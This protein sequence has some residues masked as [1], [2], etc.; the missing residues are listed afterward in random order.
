MSEYYSEKLSAER[1]KQCYEIAPPRTQQYLRAEIQ[2]ILQ[3]ITS[4]SRVLELGCGYGRVLAAMKEKCSNLVGIDISEESLAFAHNR[5]VSSNLALVL[6]NANNLAFTDCTFDAVVCI[7]NGISAFK[8]S[9]CTVIQEAVRVTAPGGVCLFSSY[10][11]HFWDSRLEWFKVQSDA[12]L[13]GPID[14]K[15]TK[16]G[17][18]VCTD[19][20]RATTLTHSD[21]T[22]TA[23][24]LGLDARIYEIDESSIFCEIIC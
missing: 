16:N 4:R 24:L 3:Y 13:I 6:M 1:L 11:E 5:F 21:F 9:P 15:Q 14:W 2:H 18:I 20:F 17:V 7:Q 23:D 22:Q 19:G 8:L 12:G 10:S